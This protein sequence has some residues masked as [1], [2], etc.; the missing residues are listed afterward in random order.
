MN[1][2]YLALLSKME[3][4]AERNRLISQYILSLPEERRKKAYLHQLNVDEKRINLSPEEFM[5]WIQLEL[6]E[7][8]LNLEDAMSSLQHILTPKTDIKPVSER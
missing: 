5:K 8:L 4:E 3:F 2:S 7:N 1:L 6:N